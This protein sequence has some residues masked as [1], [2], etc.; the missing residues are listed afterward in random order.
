MSLDLGHVGHSAHTEAEVLA[1]EGARYGPRDRGL[2][3]AGRAHEAQDLALG[4]AL[5]AADGYELE[6]ALFDVVEA[7]VVFVEDLLGGVQ[8]QA[9]G[10]GDSPGKASQPV[11]VVARH[12]KGG[13]LGVG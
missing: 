5:E 10:G 12:A 11:K 1:V 7:V 3:Y 8:V 6:D 9:L 4:G 13:K 2:A